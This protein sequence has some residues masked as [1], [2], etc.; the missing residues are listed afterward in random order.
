MFYMLFPNNNSMD[1]IVD[2]DILQYGNSP[3][4]PYLYLEILIIYLSINLQ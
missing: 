3:T 4:F 1:A 2:R